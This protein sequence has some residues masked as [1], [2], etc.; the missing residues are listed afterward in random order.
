MVIQNGGLSIVAKTLQFTSAQN[1]NTIYKYMKHYKVI[2][3]IWELDYQT[4]RI[5][6]FK[7][8]WI[9]NNHGAKEDELGFTLAD[10]IEE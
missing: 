1:R 7:F 3:G 8:N 6:I 2:R 4:F 5:L 9:K 10:L